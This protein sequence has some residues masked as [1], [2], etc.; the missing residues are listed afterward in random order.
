MFGGGEQKTNFLGQPE[1]TQDPVSKYLFP[2]EPVCAQCCPDLTYTQ[3][4]YGFGG[5]AAA[6]YL[7]SFVGTMTLIGGF[8]PKNVQTFA[9]L[10][11]VG[12]VIALSAT[13]FLMGPKKQCTN[14]WKPNRWGTTSFYLIMLIVVFAVAVADFKMNGKIWLILFLLCIQIMA[15]VWYSLSYIPY[16]RDIASKFIRSIYICAPCYFIYDGIGMFIQSTV[17]DILLASSIFSDLSLYHVPLTLTL[18]LS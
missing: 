12:N 3:R 4:L 5:C 15:G 10:Y 17:C 2:E 1:K 7:L 14:M 6:G 9:I 8:T 18:T 11:V 13:G 16:G